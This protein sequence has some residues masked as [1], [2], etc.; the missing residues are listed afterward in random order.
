MTMIALSLS[1]VSPVVAGFGHMRGWGWGMAGLGILTTLAVIGLIVWL[2]VFLA[3]S[4]GPSS[5]STPP[6]TRAS[7]ARELLNER[8]AR[9]EITREQY[10]QMREDLES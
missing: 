5:S 6:E 7:N 9:G 1:T 10:L 2:I 8:Y 4:T 3:R